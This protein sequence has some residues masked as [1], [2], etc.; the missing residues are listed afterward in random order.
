MNLSRRERKENIVK[1]DQERSL[2]PPYEEEL[3]EHQKRLNMALEDI[4]LTE[5]IEAMREL[6]EKERD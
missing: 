5:G 4:A 1:K 6:W 3:T 2:D